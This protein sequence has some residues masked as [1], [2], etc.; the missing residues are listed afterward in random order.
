MARGAGGSRHVAPFTLSA[1][2]HAAVATL[3]FNTLKE[4][5]PVALPPMYRVS[6]VAAPAGERAIGEVKSGQAKASTA[7][8]Q[9]TA[10]QSTLKEMPLPKAKPAQKTPARATPS[11]SKPA[12]KAGATDAKAAPQPKT[13]APKAG[14]G[15]V[16]GKGTD[17]ATVRSDGIEF[18]FPGYL[19]NIVRQ[20]AL[21]FKPRN[22]NARLK[23]E[24]RFLIHRDGSVSDLTFIRRSGNFSFDLEAQ[25]AVE[26]ASSARRFGPLPDGF[27]DDVLPVVFSF[28][29]E[30]LK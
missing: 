12:A 30:F 23:A 6:I 27:P 13:E 7:V 20:I 22:T 16:G 18:P 17:V 15:P 29:P 2:L 24:I 3:L 11:V 10:A 25:G 19:N 26:A 4:R 1:L 14:G 5:K 8:T 21:N 28:D 9:P